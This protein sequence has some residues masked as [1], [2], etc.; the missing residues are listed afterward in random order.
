MLKDL[1]AGLFEP[2]ANIF[3]E[4]ERRK[5]ARE[6]ANAKLAAAK[7]EG[8]QQIELNKDEWEQ[9]NV[10]GMDATWKDEY[11]T[12]SII[13]IFNL[14]VVGGIASAFGHPQLLEGIGLAVTAL[15]AQGVDVGFLLEAVA[16]SA[17]GLSVWKRL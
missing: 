9:L 4:R 16:L 5:A 14:I 1:I 10:Q 8:A 7:Q 11:V 6:A 12:V 17:V 13:S 2:V 3:A 15:G